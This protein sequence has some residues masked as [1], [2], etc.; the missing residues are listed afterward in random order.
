MAE[1]VKY[2]QR[3]KSF[4]RGRGKD[5]INVQ[6]ENSYDTTWSVAPAMTGT[7]ALRFPLLSSPLS[8]LT[9]KPTRPRLSIATQYE[10]LSE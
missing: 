1:G 4:G 3:S 10:P 7:P 9:P 2:D 5:S 8:A 6:H